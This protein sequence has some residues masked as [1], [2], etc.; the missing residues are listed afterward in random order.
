M[1]GFVVSHL[2][3]ALEIS[4]SYVDVAHGHLGIYMAE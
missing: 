2:E 4:Q 1:P 3:F